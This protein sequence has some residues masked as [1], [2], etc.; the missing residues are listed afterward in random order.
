M[1]PLT[2]YMD[3]IAALENNRIVTSADKINT[4]H[5]R[6]LCALHL[7]H[8]WVKEQSLPSC[9]TEP[10]RGQVGA[11]KYSGANS[12]SSS[13]Q[14]ES[15]TVWFLPYSKMSVFLTPS[16]LCLP[17]II[18]MWKLS[19][20]L[21]LYYTLCWRKFTGVMH[22]SQRLLVMNYSNFFWNLFLYHKNIPKPILQCLLLL[23]FIY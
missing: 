3:R 13:I 2:V 19:Y 1:N 20:G 8:S 15:K 4:Y 9:I 6:Q 7:S 12:T 16:M 14:S 5:E 23:S 17:L 22:K 21:L 10:A 11:I 18:F